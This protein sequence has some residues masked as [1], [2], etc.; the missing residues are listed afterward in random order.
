MPGNSALWSISTPANLAVIIL[1]GRNWGSIH[2]PASLCTQSLINA[3]TT[4]LG[5]QWPLASTLHRSFCKR[6]D[7]WSTSTERTTS[8]ISFITDLR[9]R[10]QV[11]IGRFIRGTLLARPRPSGC[12]KGQSMFPATFIRMCGI[13]ALRLSPTMA[14]RE[15]RILIVSRSRQFPARLIFREALARISRLQKSPR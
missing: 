4:L 14:W 5:I 2:G 7:L 6:P 12:R 13:C 3:A 15:S 8:G 10:P 9:A 11:L 1:P